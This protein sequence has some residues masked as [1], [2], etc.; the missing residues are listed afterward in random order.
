MSVPVWL[1][2]KRT[3][4]AP[5]GETITRVGSWKI[6][7]VVTHISGD[8]YTSPAVLATVWRFHL[9]FGPGDGIAAGFGDAGIHGR[10]WNT[11]CGRALGL[12]WGPR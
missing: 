9:G 8:A 1:Y 10:L 12:G 11:G 5:C 6:G 4:A 2:S 7:F 3:F